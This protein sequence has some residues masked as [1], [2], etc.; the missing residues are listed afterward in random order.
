MPD[1]VRYFELLGVIDYMYYNG[2]TPKLDVNF[3]S[4]TTE[5]VA[6]ISDSNCNSL[7]FNS[8]IIDPDWFENTNL[9]KVTLNNIEVDNSNFT[10]SNFSNIEYLKISN[11]AMI[12]LN[13]L[14]SS[15]NLTQLYLENISGITSFSGANNLLDLT[16]DNLPDLSFFD[17]SSHTNLINLKL[18]DLPLTCLLYTSPSP[19]D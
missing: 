14:D 4:N 15:T 12:D 1:S 3:G 6:G 19:R 9:K 5:F 16:I 11:Y 18:L 17:V 13:F 8:C 7:P 2:F 10:V